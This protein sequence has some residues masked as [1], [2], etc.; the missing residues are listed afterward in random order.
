MSPKERERINKKQK[1][2]REL[3][4]AL[5]KGEIYK[6]DLSPEVLERLKEKLF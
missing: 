6:E 2:L 4:E 3:V 1:D 5:D